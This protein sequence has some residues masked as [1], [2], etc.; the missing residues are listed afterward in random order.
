[1]GNKLGVIL[2]VN[3]C[4]CRKGLLYLAHGLLLCSVF[5]ALTLP[6]PARAQF[7]GKAS[8]T[9]QFE[10]NSNVFYLDSG[11]AQPG[12]N[13]FRRA[14]TF[15]AYGAEFDGDYVLGRQDLSVTASTKEYHYQRF[16]DLDHD[17]YK[18]DG[19]WNW[20]LGGLLDGKFDVTRTRTMVPFY[21]LSGSSALSLS[22]VTEQRETAQIGLKLTSDWRVEGSAYTSKA[23]EPIAEAPN[24]QLTQ[25]SGTTSIEYLGI[26]GL[27]SGLTAGYLTGDYTG[28]TVTANP[29]FSQST[30]GFLA[31]YR[32]SR[33]IVE[34]QVGYSRR[35][36]DTGTDN[37]S[38]VTGLFDVK[39]QLTPKTSFTAKIDRTINSYFLNAGSEIDTEAAAS[40]TWQA[41]YKLSVSPGY[42]FTYRDFPGQGNNP[43]GSNR[44][45]IQEIVTM[46]IT[47]QPQ[48]WLLIR[49]YADV[50]T[51]RST[52]IGA[53]YSG[54]IFGVSVTVTPYGAK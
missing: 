20:K 28:S 41:T 36:S 16:T 2:T 19:G 7:T 33:T 37:T 25:T 46:N 22:L 38:G 21:D 6:I 45:D 9:G 29:S 40:F 3:H 17:D 51:R 31:K 47:Y 27:T 49:P 23:D 35:V 14:D 8:A 44:V 10:S 32:F 52:F 24:L 5:A 43:V 30:A 4:A 39:D 13:D 12:T 11:A 50:Q 15:L 34:G 18:L 54:A 48:R 42:S 53:H 1:V 26:T